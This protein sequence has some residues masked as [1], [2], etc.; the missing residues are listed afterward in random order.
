MK[1]QYKSY[2][3]EIFEEPTYSLNSV[4]NLRNYDKVFFEGK[5]QED[6]FYPTTKNALIIKE[7]EIEI[8][9]AIICEIGGATRISE[10]SCIIEDDKIWTCICNKM[11][12]LKVPSLELEWCKAIDFVTIFAIHK[13]ENDFIVHGELEIKRVTKEGE[14]VWS[15]GGR[16]IWVN[17]E[18]KTE[19]TIEDN[20]IRLFDFES[21]EYLLNFEGKSIER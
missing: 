12:C 6:R 10:K 11:Y 7:F 20:R 13:I 2:E 17:I 19:L 5:H 8:S 21:N 16:D 18:G 9:N 15:F 4:D 3:I 14:I 1:L